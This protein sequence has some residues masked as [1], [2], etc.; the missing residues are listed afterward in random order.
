MNK[1]LFQILCLVLMMAS[2]LAFTLAFW[3]PTTG[4]AQAEVG[5]VASPAARVELGRPASGG[6]QQ[7]TPTPTPESVSHPGSTDGIMVMG[8][9]IVVIILVPILFQRSVW[10]K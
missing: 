5:A 9:A 6:H 7:L 2:G 10:K 8:I 4:A 3:P 1:A